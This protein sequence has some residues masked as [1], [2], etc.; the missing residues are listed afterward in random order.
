MS[1][2]GKLWEQAVCEWQKL[3]TDINATFDTEVVI[4]AAEIEPVV[5]WQDKP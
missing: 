3:H 5:T 4:Q 2:K 1:P